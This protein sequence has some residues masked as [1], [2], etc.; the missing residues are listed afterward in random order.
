MLRMLLLFWGGRESHSYA[1]RNNN[2][3]RVSPRHAGTVPG[4]SMT[5]KVLLTM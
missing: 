5:Y 4:T 3:P 2:L 1:I